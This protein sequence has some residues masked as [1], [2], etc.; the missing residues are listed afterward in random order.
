LDRIRA[1]E[2]RRERLKDAGALFD[3]ASRIELASDLIAYLRSEGGLDRHYSEAERLN[4]TQQD[5]TD[6]LQRAEEDA[7]GY[8]VSEYAEILDYRSHIIEQH[9]DD[10][11][12]ELATI[13]GA[14]GRQWPLVIVASFDEGELPHARSLENAEDEADALEAERR[15]AYVAM[16]R[17]RSHLVLVH[18]ID[19]ASRFI[20]E[21]APR[22]ETV[23]AEPAADAGRRPA[24][25]AGQSHNPKPPPRRGPRPLK[26]PERRPAQGDWDGRV[27]W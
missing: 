25:S 15:L 19:T 7:A 1:E 2:W 20:T 18:G 9:F 21:A 14:K 24:G 3:E 13:H 12:V 17:A 26:A 27:T 5:A 10:G 23:T 8:S 6:S 22:G 4:P 16:T 11:G